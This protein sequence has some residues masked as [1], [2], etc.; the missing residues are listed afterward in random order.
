MKLEIEVYRS[1]C[2]LSTFKINSIKADEDDFV[3]KYDHAPEVAEDYACGDMRADIIPATNEVLTK[4]GI[5]PD[6]YSKIA[7]QVSE[8]VSFGCCGLCV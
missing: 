4:Y 5:S 6:E 1:L 8:K 3:D 7:E 2:S